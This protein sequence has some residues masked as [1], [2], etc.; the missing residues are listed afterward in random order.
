MKYTVCEIR[1]SSFSGKSGY[2]VFWQKQRI[3]N[4]QDDLY[5]VTEVI[6]NYMAE[7]GWKFEQMVQEKNLSKSLLIFSKVER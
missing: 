5:F 4:S 2:D 6:L 3:Y 7:Q 1:E